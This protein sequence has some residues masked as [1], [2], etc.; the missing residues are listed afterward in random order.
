M[1][2]AS[3]KA[4]AS[5]FVR[6]PYVWTLQALLSVI[7]EG[8]VSMGLFF[9]YDKT[10]LPG[11]F[12]WLVVWT[13]VS[14][15]AAFYK[16][17]SE[18]SRLMDLLTAK[19]DLVFAPTGRP[20]DLYDS[21]HELDKHPY[22]LRIFRVGVVNSGQTV[23]NVAVM[24]NAIDPPQVGI[25]PKQELTRTHHRQKDSRFDVNRSAKPNAFVDVAWQEL[26]GKSHTDRTQ[27][28]MLNF[29]EGAK[30]MSLSV[31][32][33]VLTLAIDGEGAAEERRY[34]L[35]RNAIGQYD[36]AAL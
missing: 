5:A 7:W 16:F 20:D 19:L 15:V 34:I 29:S 22:A 13:V 1:F 4:K 36:M 12:K 2:K 26:A 14:V 11:Y 30:V 9:G 28:I 10:D 35:S 25:F 3:L 23:K 21:F 6:G 27:K 33:Y 18:N 32:K 31:D 24:V 17:I 8:F